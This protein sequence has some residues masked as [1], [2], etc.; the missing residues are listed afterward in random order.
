[1]TKPLLGFLLS[2]CAFTAL[3]AGSLGLFAVAGGVPEDSALHGPSLCNA[4]PALRR[5][6]GV[7]PAATFDPELLERVTTVV[8]DRVPA[9]HHDDLRRLRRA[10]VPSKR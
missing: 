3:G 10:I 6:P 1:M 9:E 5:E 2:W 7:A 8:R 4:E